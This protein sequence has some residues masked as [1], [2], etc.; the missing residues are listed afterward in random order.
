[1]NAMLRRFSLLVLFAAL[2]AASAAAQVWRAMGP[3]G[4][5][6]RSLAADP[7]DPQRL[8]LGTADGHVFGSAD[9]GES[10]ELLGRAGER[11]DGV[12]MAIRVD[13]RDSRT[14]YVAS[15]KMDPLAG[16]GFYR[17]RDGGRTWEL[18]GLGGLHVRALAQAPSDP[19]IL[20]AGTMEGVFRSRDAGTTWERISPEGDPE[21]RQLDS[22]AIDPRNPDVIYIGT[23]HLPWKT[24]DGGQ[25]WQAI[26]EGMIDDSDVFSIEIDRTNPRRIYASACSGIYRSDNA[27]ALWQ[28]IQGIP[29][30]ARRTHVIR[31][32]PTRPETI[33]AGTTEGL[34]RTTNAG[35]TWQRLTPRHWVINA[36]ALDPARP[37][38]IVL[39]TERLGVMVSDD[40]GKSFRAANRGFNHRQI[41]S[42]ALD[43]DRPGR[44]LAVLT[45]APEPILATD[46]GGRTW[47]PLGPGLSAEGL[48]GVYATPDGWWAAL[49][50]G[51]LMRYDEKAGRWV[52][53]GTVIGEAAMARDRRGNLVPAR[54]PQPLVQRVVDMA[55]SREA[56]FAATPQG[57]LASR[58]RGRTWQRFAF[59][60]LDLPVSSVRVSDDGRDLRIVSLRGMVFSRDGGQSWSWHDL[61]F[62]SG[63]A[64]RLEVVDD[65]TLLATAQQ[66]LYLSRDGGRSWQHVAS[67]LPTVPVRALAVLG[68][69][70]LASV[71]TG[72]LYLS[73]DR[74]QNWSRVEGLLA[75]GHF[76]VITAD[77]SGTL[78]FA[79]SST[80]GLYAVDLRPRT[81]LAGTG[82]APE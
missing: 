20:V 6:V 32:H 55:F 17:S 46:D 80:E 44:I 23:Y 37:E 15:W 41:V 18:A 74:G 53:A 28:K 11:N 75:E 48:L 42:L 66:G 30:S 43:R 27:G 1:M 7:N 65:S 16:G 76:P 50:R 78:I 29:Y 72:G 47:E 5:D 70:F 82:A 54:G 21:L 64:Q 13:P 39:G 19:D 9:G 22:V 31:Q 12:V 68:D 33:Y 52:A 59:A 49:E 40:G 2:A 58:D 60:P 61:P 77:D 14:L 3:P 71:E 79:A 8:Y 81:D 57:L 10:W 25:S 69:T 24:T 73:T 67:G 62:G 45:N 36:L 56:W 26:H 35:A 34:W 4:G 51:G 63:G 38:R